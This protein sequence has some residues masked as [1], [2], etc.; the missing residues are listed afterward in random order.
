MLI[1]GIRNT[2]AMAVSSTKH[3]SFNLLTSDSKK[4]LQSWC[5]FHI[6][7]QPISD[8]QGLYT[9]LRCTE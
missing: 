2:D 6:R 4:V 3:V 5:C 9:G 1:T 7:L 8:L